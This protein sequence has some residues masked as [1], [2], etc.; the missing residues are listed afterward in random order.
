VEWLH[1]GKPTALGLASGVVA[2]LVAVT[3][4]SGFVQP[5]GALAIGVAAGAVCYGAVLL[6][7]RLKYDDSLDA[8]GVHGV[9]G[10]LG[11]VLTGVFAAQ[12][13][14]QQANGFV[15]G[16]EELG[17]L[18]NGRAYQ[19]GVQAVAALASA[20]YAF[21]MTLVL[22]FL[23]DK[24]WGFGL[25]AEAENEGLDQSEHGEVGFDLG[26]SALEEAAEL[27]RPEPR[28]AAVPPD[29]QKRFTVVVEGPPPAELMQAWSALCQAG[30]A[31]PTAEF[32]A[33]YPH[34]TTVQGNRFR[35]RDGDR[36]L[37][38][39]SLQRLFQERL[40]GPVQVRVEE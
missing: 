26:P 36:N 27:P 11:A 8:F 25:D 14:W 22:V 32:R 40:G 7:P 1:K 37:I 2:G 12:L 16:T 24:L 15:P 17:K 5:L 10:L 38:R 18:N 30:A 31:P 23:I 29:G 35:F 4:A 39:A 9:G 3:P 34:V 28:A 19:V 13:Y 20:G 6:K 21:L 33:V